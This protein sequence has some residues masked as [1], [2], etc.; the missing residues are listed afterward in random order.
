MLCSSSERASH[1]WLRVFGAVRPRIRGHS[2][3][4][5]S[6]CASGSDCCPL[7]SFSSGPSY[8]ESSLLLPPVTQLPKICAVWAGRAVMSSPKDRDGSPRGSVLPDSRDSTGAVTCWPVVPALTQCSPGPARD[9]EGS[10]ASL[11]LCQKRKHFPVLTSGSRQ[12][13]WLPE[14]DGVSLRK[15][16][17]LLNVENLKASFS[18]WWML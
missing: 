11:Q 4:R 10:G 13:A 1:S 14:G 15:S 18:A 6:A 17:L 8:M 7:T 5:Q 3:A 2:S 16:V 12:C 9:W